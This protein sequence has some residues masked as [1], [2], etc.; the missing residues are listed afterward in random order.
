MATNDQ[1]LLKQ[2]L[3][4]QRQRIAPELDESSFF[5]LFVAE[6]VLKEYEFSWEELGYGHTG[7]GG[8]GGIDALYV[9]VNGELLR[10]DTDVSALRRD[11]T[12]EVHIIQAKTSS[13]FSEDAIRKFRSST[14]D[15]FALDKNLDGLR[16]VYNSSILEITGLF[17]DAYQELISRIPQLNLSYYYAALAAEVH[18]N[19][20]RL[21]GEIKESVSNL[22]S[23]AKM[24]F[25]FLDA[26]KLL[27]MFRRTPRVVF[28]LKLAETPISTGSGGY[29]CL[30]T[31]GDYFQFITDD[32]RRCNKSLFDANVRDYQGDV[33]VNK[34]IRETLKD[35]DAREDFW[36]LNNG[37]TVI[38]TRATLS[39]KTLTMESPQIVNGLQTSL[40]IYNYFSAESSASDSRY[41]LVRVITPAEG[42]DS[43]E[44]IIRATNS[45]TSIPQASLRATD[46]IHRDIEDYFKP[47]GRYYDRR[48]N[49]YKNE[50][51]L[52]SKIVSISYVAQAVM[53]VVLARPNDARA[54]P[55]TLL[56]DDN[57]YR[58]V[59]NP[60]YPLNLFLNSVLVLKHIEELLRSG[61]EGLSTKEINNVK[62]HLAMY[63]V[64]RFLNK[65][66]LNAEEISNLEVDDMDGKIVNNC[67]AEVLKIYQD[68]GGDDTV[69]KGT[70][71]VPKLDE[72]LEQHIVSQRLE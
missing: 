21:V 5:D 19:V 35:R 59:F 39:G 58:K 68:L 44:R 9:L 45:Q 47:R 54:R 61:D 40:E 20:E 64:R 38:A 26:R 66:K 14:E 18:P 52:L 22:F 33:Q 67:K 13:G 46:R 70:E 6:Q 55:S 4:E 7:Q 56:K 2:V 43:Y 69:A 63:V 53:S 11:V 12:I 31:L 65:K 28:N 16:S 49:F 48:K 27:D 10:E 25:D 24:T 36:W 30:V 37:V 34:G 3:D 42:D 29:V 1:V 41:I 17:G 32:A 15:L 60:D 8:D 50:G 51:R 57:D 71:F 62:F 72:L 23:N